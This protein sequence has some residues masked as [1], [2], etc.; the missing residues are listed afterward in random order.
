MAV[1]SSAQTVR[2]V[3]YGARTPVGANSAASAA[4]VR[5]SVAMFADHPYMI[6]KDGAPMVVARDAFLSEEALG[7]DRFVELGLPAALEALQ[8]AVREREAIVPLQMLLG[9]PTQRPGLPKQ[10][11][12][13]V[14]EALKKGLQKHAHITTTQTISTG[15]SAGLMALEEAT[16]RVSSGAAECCLVGG[17]ESYMEPETL[18]WVDERDCLHSESNSW[19]FI[20]G[21]AAGFCLLCSQGFAAA[22]GLREF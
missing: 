14:T 13:K 21:E 1:P 7:V 9:L 10:L 2:L 16:R 11:Q 4:A 6:S 12:E 17:I 15:H 22:H 20:P 5:A 19:G 18:E 8:P 3:G